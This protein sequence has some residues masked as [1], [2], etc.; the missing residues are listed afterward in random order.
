MKFQ[1]LNGI[2]M[3]TGSRSQLYRSLNFGEAHYSYNVVFQ[4]LKNAVEYSLS[5]SPIVLTH[6]EIYKS[7]LAKKRIGFFNNSKPIHIAVK[8][9]EDLRLLD[10]AYNIAHI[11]W[12]FNKLPTFDNKRVTPLEKPLFSLGLFNE[13]WVGCDYTKKILLQQGLSNI[14]VIPCPIPTPNKKKENLY[15]LLIDSNA[16]NLNF[17]GSNGELKHALTSLINFKELFSR[18]YGNSHPKIYLT[19]ANI[20]DYRKNLPRLLNC[21]EKF[22]NRHKNTALVVKLVI[23]NKSTCLNNINEILGI[24]FSDVV[25]FGNSDG[26]FFISDHF[27]DEGLIKLINT[28]D[29]YINLSHAEGQCLP[30]LE[31]MACGVVPIS[32]RHTAMLDYISPSNSYVVDSI[33]VDVPDTAPYPKENLKWFDFSENSVDSALEKSFF[34]DQEVYNQLSLE[35]IKTA[36]DN[37]SY[38]EIQNKILNRILKIREL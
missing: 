31:A 4:R 21:F 6:P 14:H 2:Y 13:I 9:P 11:A 16:I 30:I 27:S 20:W 12:E 19:V 26:I 3:S 23:D 18:K 1:N 8:S 24:H 29:F 36:R 7:D 5:E 38:E 35:S 10:G 37:Y 34:E 22:H 15:E 28:A 33:E 25:E 32:C 17:K